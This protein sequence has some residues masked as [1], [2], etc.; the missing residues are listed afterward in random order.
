MDFQINSFII[1]M[2]MT[3]VLNIYGWATMERQWKKTKKLDSI[4]EYELFLEKFPDSKYRDEAFSIIKKRFEPFQSVQTMGL[5]TYG[6]IFCGELE[7]KLK[8]FITI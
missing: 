1:V 3:V 7:K 6:K 4:P 8:I 5:L 2:I